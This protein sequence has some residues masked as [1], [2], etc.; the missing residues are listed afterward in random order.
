MAPKITLQFLRLH[1]INV[2]FLR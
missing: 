2:T 1:V